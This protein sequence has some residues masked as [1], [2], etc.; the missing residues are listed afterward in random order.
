MVRTASTMLPLGT[1]APDFALTDTTGATVR[2]SDFSHAKGLVVVFM[3]NHCPYVKHVAP[4]L[5]RLASEYQG[6]GIAFVGIN[7]NDADNYPEDSPEK[8]LEEKTMRGYTFP[9]LFDVDQSVAR[10]Y[11][12]ACTPDFYLFDAAMRL[13]YRGQMDSSRPKSDSVVTGADLRAAL[14]AVLTGT[15][16][17]ENQIASIGCNIKWRSGSE[18]EYFNPAGTA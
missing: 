16:V 2:L 5:Q 3:C 14:D 8:M 17:S 11:R 7:S 4:E 9:Y 10:A 13:A 6:K 15:P 18:P 1:G 12:A